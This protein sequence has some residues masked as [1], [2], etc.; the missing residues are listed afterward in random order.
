MSKRYW[1][2]LQDST[3]KRLVKNKVTIQE[4][5]KRYKQPDWCEYP[6]ALEG[7]MGCWSLMD[8]MD[9][10]HKIS[11]EYCASCECCKGITQKEHKHKG[12][13]IVCPFCGHKVWW[14]NKLHST[15]GHV[16]SQ[17]EDNMHTPSRFVTY[18]HPAKRN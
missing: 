1:H 6:N 14:N 4:C 13:S 3:I 8:S 9:L 2:K 5:M 17:K 10:R 7:V 12:D 15:C 18:F 11:L 16:Y